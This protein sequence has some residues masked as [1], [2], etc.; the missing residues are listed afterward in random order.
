MKTFPLCT[1]G[2][3]CYNTGKYVI[4]AIECVGRQ[5]YPNIQHIIIDDC[6]TDN[7]AKEVQEWIETNNYNCIFIKH[8]VNKGVQYGIKEIFTLAEGKYISFVS[9]DLW[10]DEKL[11]KQI[12]L[13][14]KLDESYAMIYGDSKMIDKDG[15]VMIESLFENYRGKNFIPPSGNIF[16]EVV[17]DFFFFTQACIIKLSHFNKIKSSFDKEIISE[18]WDWQLALSRNFNVL[19]LNEVFAYYRWHDT[20]IGRTQWTEEKRH[21]VWLSHAKMFLS[22]YNHPKNNAKD[23]LLILNRILRIYYELTHLPNFNKMDGFKLLGKMYVLTRSSRIILI[24]LKNIV[25][26]SVKLPMKLYKKSSLFIGV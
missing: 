24:F 16:S 1:I 21:K 5:K 8:E 9:D 20:S 6:S 23:K 7:S 10:P 18:D 25:T 4:E 19:G 3:L 13:F 22:Y 2:T 26:I 11:I 17:K 15:N 14:E 12:S